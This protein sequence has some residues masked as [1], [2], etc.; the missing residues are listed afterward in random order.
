[1]E[2]LRRI[3]TAMKTRCSNPNATGYANYGGRGICVCPEWQAYPPFKDWAL[4]NGY[5][6]DLSIDRIDVAG[7][8]C[9]E[10]CRWATR[11]EQAN[12][13]RANRRLTFQGRT[14]T[15]RQWA[16]EFGF[17]ANQISDR[18]NTLKWPIER[19]LTEAIGGSARQYTF[20]GETHTL[21]E[22]ADIIGMRYCALWNRLEFKKWPMELAIRKPKKGRTNVLTFRG[23]SLTMKE[24]AD[25][26]GMPF[27]TLWKRIKDCGWDVERALTTPVRHYWRKSNRRNSACS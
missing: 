22:W 26:Q 13:T 2:R 7:D 17:S 6:D 1:M 16:K 11:A 12:N 18:I 24:W 21:H 27:V 10:N 5:A 14:M 9:P 8:Y 3:H 20:E 4:A 23:E 19:A 15:L 25:K